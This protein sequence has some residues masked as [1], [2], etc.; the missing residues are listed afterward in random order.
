MAS[1]TSPSDTSSFVTETRTERFSPTGGV[2]CPVSIRIVMTTPSRTASKS[3][4]GHQRKDDGQGHDHQR[5]SVEKTTEDEIDN[6]HGG[7]YRIGAKAGGTNQF[8]DRLRDGEKAHCLREHSC[9][10]Y[11]KGDGSE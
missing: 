3:Q 6:D 2:T 8:E 10:H 9:A 5:Q 4:P 11:D 1:A 7:K